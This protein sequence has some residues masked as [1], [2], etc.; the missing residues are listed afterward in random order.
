MFVDLSVDDEEEEQ[1]GLVPASA[2]DAP[3]EPE[4]QG[5][6]GNSASSR[7]TGRVIGII[8]RNWRQ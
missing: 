5:G 1:V 7:P 3:R 4:I 2:D 8:K 6:A